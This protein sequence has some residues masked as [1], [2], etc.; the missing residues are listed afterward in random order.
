MCL[1][2]ALYCKPDFRG[3]DNQFLPDVFL[4]SGAYLLPRLAEIM[5]H[6]PRPTALHFSTL[7]PVF[8]D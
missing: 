5:A 7:Q 1:P 8:S 3:L 6:S 4:P 2:Q